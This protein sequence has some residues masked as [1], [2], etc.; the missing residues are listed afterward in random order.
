MILFILGNIL[1]FHPR[2]S[3]ETCYGASPLLWWGV[4][5]VVGIGYI[6]LAQ[7]FF[8]VVIVGLGG[9]IVLVSSAPAFC[10]F[11]CSPAPLCYG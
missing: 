11:T 9:A 1:L 8:V 3:A 6:L 10:L 4:M 7:I 2:P 5:L